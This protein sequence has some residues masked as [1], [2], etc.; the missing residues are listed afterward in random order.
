MNRMFFEKIQP[1]FDL[2]LGERLIWCNRDLLSQLVQRNIHARYRGSLFGL[3]WSFIQ[4]LLML[5]IY[6]FVFGVIFQLRW[7]GS[8]DSKSAF[9]V[10]MLC[11]MSIFQIFSESVN[12]SCRIIVGNRN[13]VKKVRF[14]LEILPVSQVFSALILGSAWF[15]LILLGVIFILGSLNWTILLLPLT[16]IP[17][18]FLSLGCSWF[19]A[20]LGVYV[21]DT[22]YCVAVILQMLYFMTPIFY[23]TSAVPEGF[24]WLH[25]INPLALIVEETRKILVYGVLPDWR[26]LALALAASIVVAQLG[27]LWFIRTKRG[28]A[29]VI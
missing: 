17:L 16:L 12:G 25:R 7:G 20:S 29:D 15:I 13:Y 23:P 9:A 8:T 4:P 27:L 24:R 11:G 18:L 1:L 26:L 21:R 2:S 22:P 28:F 10:V 5:C 3:L 19:V 6:T 14:P